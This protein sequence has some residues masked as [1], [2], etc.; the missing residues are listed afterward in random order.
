MVST[1]TVRGPCGTSDAD[2][3]SRPVSA[4]SQTRC[5]RPLFNVIFSTMAFAPSTVS[6]P[7]TSI[8]LPFCW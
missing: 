5:T 4:S 6:G 8:A 7:S 2:F 3:T 1:L